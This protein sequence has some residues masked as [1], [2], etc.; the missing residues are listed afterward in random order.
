[1]PLPR[2]GAKV[3]RIP[4]A[5]PTGRET[6]GSLAA[7][8]QSASLVMPEVLPPLDEPAVEEISPAF[9]GQRGEPTTSALPPWEGAEA[10]EEEVVVDQTKAPPAAVQPTA[11]HAP[12]VIPPRPQTVAAVVDAPR[13]G[14]E[15]RLAEQGFEGLDLGAGFGAFPSVVLKDDRFSTSDGDPLGQSFFCVIHG[16]KPKWIVKA[17]DT[18]KKADYK[19]TR[20]KVNDTSGIPLTEAFAEWRKKGVMRGEP[21]WKPYLDVTAQL[22]S[23]EKRELGQVVILQI[24]QTSIEKIRGYLIQIG[25]QGFSP[26]EVITQVGLGQKVT[27]VDYPFWPW[28]FKKWG[29]LSRFDM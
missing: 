28:H 10:A 13:G 1:M 23:V 2:P 8:A 12:A 17:N 21:V 29:P 4:E 11:T 9:H 25:L 5:N 14:I 15:A 16:S 26:A 20:D 27:S 18:D 24:P 19:Y 6:T 3:T 22:V 7:A